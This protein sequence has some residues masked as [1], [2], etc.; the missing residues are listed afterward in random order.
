LRQVCCDPRLVSVPSARRVKGSAKCELFFELLTQQLEQGVGQDPAPVRRSARMIEERTKHVS[1]LVEQILDVSRLVASRMQLERSEIDLVAMIRKLAGEID[2]RGGPHE[3][4]LHHPHELLMRVDSARVQQV[5]S[6]LIDNA[7][8]FSPDGGPI[9]LTV[10]RRPDTI[11]LVVRDRG[12]GIPEEF[13]EHV[14]DRFHQAH[15]GAFRSG[16]GL[17]LHISREIIVLHGGNIT[18]VFPA[19]GG[20]EFT[21]CLPLPVALAA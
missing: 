20:S 19:D 18:A 4:R 11:A 14:F 15:A 7:V 12:L 8:R 17:G 2:R 1:R 5:M 6:N 9:D 10:E 13:R 21:V 16:M 3:F